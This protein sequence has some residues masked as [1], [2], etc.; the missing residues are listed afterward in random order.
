MNFVW[1]T[2]D[3][4][5]LPLA[6]RLVEEGHKVTVYIAHENCKQL[7][8][9]MIEKADNLNFL[10]KDSERRTYIILDHVGF[11]KPALKLRKIVRTMGE[12]G[13]HLRELGFKVFGASVFTERLELDRAFAKEV[14]QLVGIAVP[15]TVEFHSLKEALEFVRNNKGRWVFKPDNN[16]APTFVATEPDSSD[17]IE[18]ILTLIHDKGLSNNTSGVL[19]EHIDGVECSIE[20]WY[21]YGDIIPG[22]LNIT[23]ETKVAFPGQIGPAVGCST[24]AVCPVLGNSPLFLQT[25]AK[26]AGVFKRFN[27]TAPVDI[28][29]ITPPPPKPGEINPVFLEFCGGRFGYSAIFE[30]MELLENDLGEL[31]INILDRKPVNIRLRAAWGYGIR[32]WHPPAPWHADDKEVQKAVMKEIEGTRVWISKRAPKEI[33][34]HIWWQD[35]KLTTVK[36]D[37]G[38]RQV[39]VLVGT[40]GTICEITGVGQT[41]P[42]AAAMAEYFLKFL[43]TEHGEHYGR[44]DGG[45]PI[46]YRW[47]VIQSWKLVT[48]PFK[49]QKR[50]EVASSSSSQALSL[51]AS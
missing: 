45:Q 27:V 28:N 15:K 47:G 8:D 26:L 24:S 49:S 38:E 29:T 21:Q 33:H 50:Q 7:Y 10:A 40:D 14:C 43:R 35:V 25:L 11:I 30:F 2:L 1:I 39:M 44:V 12:L 5:G 17:L 18:H 42:K 4:A 3:G 37:E 46:Q 32:V 22:S 20:G 19:E 51:S 9:G 34:K 48:P 23:L 41:I 31:L 6:Q 13:D 36:R 16:V